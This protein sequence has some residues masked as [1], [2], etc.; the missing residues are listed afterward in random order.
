MTIVL[1][2]I[3][4]MLLVIIHE[5]GHFISAKKSGVKVEE[6]GIGIPPKVMTLRKDKS[7]TKY[8]LN[9][10]PLWGFVRLKGEDPENPETFRAKDSFIKAK[11]WKKIIIL[12]AGITMN[13]IA[14]WLIFTT[15]FTLGTKP[16]Q[17]VPDNMVKGEIHSL[18]TPTKSFLYEQWLITGDIEKDVIIQDIYSD[19]LASKAWIKSGDTIIS[20]N[21][22]KVN[23][24]NIEKTLKDHIGTTF[25]IGYKHQWRITTKSITCPEGDCIMGI[26]YIS[27]INPENMKEI[28][29]PLLT[30]MKYGA[31]EIRAQTRMTLWFLG[32]FGKNIITL[33]RTNIKESLSKMTWPAWAIKF[34]EMILSS[35]WRKLYLGFAGMISLA[36]AIF[37]VLPIP[38]LDWGRLLGV[39]IQ[40]VGRLKEEKYFNIEWYIN[41]IF[42]VLL[43]GLGIYILLQDLVRMRGWNIPFIGW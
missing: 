23:T 13:T 17:I 16:I 28:K 21:D 8:T 1:G 18:L 4:F 33:Q 43:M 22:T 3:M 25:D 10:I 9:L 15:I 40:R 5:L 35:G 26:T 42:F 24:R 7:G 12:L 41:L 38:A 30:A 39:L 31:K 29:F 32:S 27:S 37:N 11:L 6:F 34:G 20:V 19:G 2:I 14:A 36:L